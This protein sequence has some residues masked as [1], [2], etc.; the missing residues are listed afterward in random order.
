MKNAIVNDKRVDVSTSD[1]V[2]YTK[3]D[4][5]IDL[6]THFKGLE[7]PN[8]PWHSL[9]LK[10]L[11]FV[12][13]YHREVLPKIKEVIS[14]QKRMTLLN[15]EGDKISGLLDS[16]VIWEDGKTYLID[17]KSSSVKYDDDSARK[18]DQL[19]LYHYIEKDNVKLDGV[20][21]VVLDKNIN[22]NKKKICKSCGSVNDGSHK[23]CPV[24]VPTGK[25]GSSDCMIHK[26][27]EGEFTVEFAPTVNVD[28]VF[29]QIAPE[30]EDRVI[31]I[32]DTTNNNIANGLFATS[33]NPVFSKFGPCDYYK[34][35]PGN[36]DFFIKEKRK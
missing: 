13:T 18:S 23:T 36:P 11:L 19:T 12:E 4:L 20:G 30:D 34:Y 31:E 33:H 28:Y 7:H 32:F 35:Y 14:I 17:N 25:Y 2:I 3:R 21:F 6:L 9:C 1:V 22:M 24:M 26:R 27:C 8:K 16:V 5:D 10:G 29:D 15:A